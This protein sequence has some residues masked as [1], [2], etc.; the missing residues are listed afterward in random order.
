MQFVLLIH[1]EFTPIKEKKK[2]PKRG[3]LWY[4]YDWGAGYL[5]SG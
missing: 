2:D 5:S 1:R 3:L 4:D